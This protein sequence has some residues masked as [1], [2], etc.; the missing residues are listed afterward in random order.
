M[1]PFEQIQQHVRSAATILK[2]SDEVVQVLTRPEAVRESVLTVTTSKGEES[3]PAYR[4]QFNSARGPYKGGI[5][6]H[7]KADQDEVQAL[8]LAMAVKCAV[9][10]LPLGGA[11]GGVT[12]NPKDYT[13]ADIESVSRA[14]VESFAEYLGVDKDIPAPDVNTTPDIM[15][16]MLDAYETIMGRSEPGMITGKPLALGGSKGRDTATAQGGVYIIKEH[17]RRHNMELAQASVA[18]QGYGN[19]GAVV[20]K[21]LAADGARIVSVSDSKGTISNEDGL[22][23][24]RLDEAKAAGMSVTDA[25]CGEVSENAEKVLHT[26]CDILIPAALDNAIRADNVSGVQTSLVL[27]LANNPVTPEAEVLLTGKGVSVIPDVLANAGGVTVSYFEWVQNRMQ[28]YWEEEEVFSK[29]KHIMVQSYTD[30][31]EKHEQL[32]GTTYRQA[33][34]ALALE[35]IVEAMKKRGRV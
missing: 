26:K 29:L 13:K 2:L 20:A 8:A 23:L 10:G 30:V 1:S 27:E 12:F 28:Y 14:Y 24:A 15:S 11:K 9:V 5:R 4:V 6:F 35:R 7:P 3:F 31:A 17:L 25:T 19:A 22:S 33:A 32:Q 18:I 16:Y 34:Y 21:L